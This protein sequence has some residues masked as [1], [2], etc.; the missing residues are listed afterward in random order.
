MYRLGRPADGAGSRRPSDQARLGVRAAMPR[1][2]WRPS[3]P[4]AGSGPQG[5][6]PRPRGFRRHASGPPAPGDICGSGEGDLLGRARPR[7][8]RPVPAPS[9]RRR[10]RSRPRGEPA[11]LAPQAFGPGHLGYAPSFT[12]RT[13]PGGGTAPVHGALP[14]LGSSQHRADRARPRAPRPRPIGREMGRLSR[15]GTGR[16][17]GARRGVLSGERQR[18]PD[19]ASH[20]S[21]ASARPQVDSPRGPPDRSRNSRAERETGN[22][23]GRS[24]LIRPRWICAADR[25]G[26]PHGSTDASGTGGPR[27][28]GACRHARVPLPAEG[29]SPAGAADGRAPSGGTRCPRT[30][31]GD[32][33]P[34]HLDRAPWRGDD[35]ADWEGRRGAW[36]G[37]PPSPPR[38][39]TPCGARDGWHTML[40]V[41]RIDARA[42]APRTRGARRSGRRG[43][44]V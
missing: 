3:P 16:R 15:P 41:G 9:C 24:T 20:R 14:A 39:A 35:F 11:D 8:S 31:R 33:G 40:R 17:A 6:S 19:R 21:A 13:S 25:A 30:G 34:P 22:R 18:P 36:A 10:A 42:P 26:E 43:R 7:A 37:D 12:S 28:I 44:L 5:P 1:R 27:S 29:R 38:S 2:S 4:R 23:P 32:R